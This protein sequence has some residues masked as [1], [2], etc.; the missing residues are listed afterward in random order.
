M[1]TTAA[2]LVIAQFVPISEDNPQVRGDVGAPPA[3]KSILRRA[4]YDC[5]SNETTWRWYVRIAPVSWIA[6]HHV[7]KARRRLN[8]SEWAD[9][10][11]DP[12]T[13][14]HKLR[15]IARLTRLG[16]MPPW[17]HSFIEPSDR[18]SDADRDQI[19]TWAKK[20]ASSASAGR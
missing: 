7:N 12:E 13:E 16:M 11:Y 6:S 1:A 20:A 14:M 4:C 3:I 9:Y 19:V 18:L 8:F 10:A 2:L 15:D 17:Y 5:H